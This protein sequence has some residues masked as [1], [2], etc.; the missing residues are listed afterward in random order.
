MLKLGPDNDDP[1]KWSIWGGPCGEKPELLEMVDRESFDNLKSL[2]EPMVNF[3]E[4]HK[5]F[6]LDANLVGAF[7][8]YMKSRMGEL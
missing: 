7:G 3:M 6:L 2:M 8:V 5:E 4:M 1:S